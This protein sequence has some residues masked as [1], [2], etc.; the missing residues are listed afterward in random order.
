VNKHQSTI[1]STSQRIPSYDIARAL[2][3]FLMVVENYS[4]FMRCWGIGPG[5]LRWLVEVSSGRAAPLF[6][7]LAGVGMSLMARQ[8]SSTGNRSEKLMVRSRLWKR[9]AFFFIAGLAYYQFEWSAGILQFYGI[10]MAIGAFLLFTPAKRLWTI[11]GLVILMFLLM[12]LFMNYEAGWDPRPQYYADFWTLVGFLRNLLF[13]GFHPVIPWLAFLLA[14][15]W[16]GRQDLHD[17]TKRRHIILIAGSVAIV[18]EIASL[19]L[20]HYLGPWL[21]S[22]GISA[23]FSRAFVP[24]LPLY[25]IQAGSTA[26]C[27]ISLCIAL[28]ERFKG[29]LCLQPL[30]FTGQMSLTVYAV[31]MLAAKG[32]LKVFKIH[33]N[34]SLISSCIAALA[35]FAMAMIFSYFW[36]KRFPH[37]PIEWVMRKLTG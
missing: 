8:A 28:A 13:N 24:P 6:V 21:S 4:A 9:A 26:I 25:M 1:E 2:A 16:L 22:E 36:R 5:W 37:G 17:R 31:H 7:V 10:Y 18:T 15:V 20:R 3:I 32:I 19:L 11:I 23:Y 34:P 30:V 27:I 35:F 29:A 33:E 12:F 14:G